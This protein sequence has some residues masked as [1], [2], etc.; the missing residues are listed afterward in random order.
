M[1]EILYYIKKF[2]SDCRFATVGFYFIRI[3]FQCTDESRACRMG[4]NFSEIKPIVIPFSNSDS[5]ILVLLL[6]Y[7]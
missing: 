5:G 1:G 4:I 6:F 2:K 7:F 3:L